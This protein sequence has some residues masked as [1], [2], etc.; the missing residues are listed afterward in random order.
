MDCTSLVE[1][2]LAIGRVTVLILGMLSGTFTIYLGWKLYRERVVS[3]SVGE[4]NFK[5]LRIALTAAGPGVFLALFGAYLL[6][7]V[8]NRP[9]DLSQ[10]LAPEAVESDS[11]EQ[12]TNSTAPVG[13]E[14]QFFLTSSTSPAKPLANAQNRC[15]IFRRTITLYS[16]DRE[17]TAADADSSLEVAFRVLHDRQASLPADS[18]E[19]PELRR[20]MLTVQTLR[21]GVARKQ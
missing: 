3:R 9:L 4:L 1:T 6:V 5:D 21:A 19:L 17:I 13:V 2:I 7:T 8:I 15:L 12:K 11:S 10:S 16:G 20:A 14:P 18:Q